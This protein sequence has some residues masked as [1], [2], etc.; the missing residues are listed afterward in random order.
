MQLPGSVN[1]L[2]VHGYWR[3]VFSCTIQS[4]DVSTDDKASVDKLLASVCLQ[5]RGL[6]CL[7]QYYSPVKFEH[8]GQLDQC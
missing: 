8:T 6:S 5:D 7:Q 2:L 3:L 4:P 1:E